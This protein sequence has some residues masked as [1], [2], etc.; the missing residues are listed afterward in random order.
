MGD[1]DEITKKRL[2]KSFDDKIRERPP[3]YYTM[4]Q[5]SPVGVQFIT[6]TSAEDAFALGMTWQELGNLVVTQ[7]Q[8]FSKEHI[9]TVFSTACTPKDPPDPGGDKS[10]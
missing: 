3:G 5:T 4:V 9:R 8:P 10:A 6:W 1:V 2:K 7:G